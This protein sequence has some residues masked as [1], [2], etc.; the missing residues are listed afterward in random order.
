MSSE[1]MP[2]GSQTFTN[3]TFSTQKTDKV[4][5]DG[6][7]EIVRTIDS[8]SSTMNGKQFEN[9][10]TQ[11]A[12]GFP[13]RVKVS[14]TGKVLE[15]QAVKDSLDETS[16][17]ILEAFRSQLMSQPSFPATPV[18]INASWHDST[19]LIQQ[20]QMGT[21]TTEIKYSTALV[22]SDTIAGV[23]VRVLKM[24]MSLSGAIEGG[25][26]TI[27]GTGGGNVY[28]SDESGKEMK[29]TLDVDQT[30]N[31]NSPRGSMTMTMKTTTTRELMK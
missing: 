30:M 7:A 31:M 23:K 4:N 11:G 18:T 26:G 13:L 21:L 1:A 24:N 20:T 25:A 9:P 19:T 27:S 16:K 6:G 2:G 17:A 15:V 14:S 29:S 28:F 3:E 10:R 12:T 5:S 22:G 8:T